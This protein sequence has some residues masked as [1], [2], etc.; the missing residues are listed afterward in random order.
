MQNNLDAANLSLTNDLP[1][2]EA[3]FP[4]IPTANDV[5]DNESLN[6][7]FE[8][9][10]DVAS[11]Y[12]Y[13]R[14]TGEP[15]AIESLA[16]ARQLTTD[17]NAYV[18]LGLYEPSEDTLRMVQQAFNLHELAIEDATVEHQRAKI[19]TY[20]EECIFI[21][22]RTAKLEERDILYGTTSIF[23][24]KQFV[25]SIRRGASHSYKAVRNNYHQHPN[26]LKMGPSF[27]VHAIL[28]FIVDNY[29][30]IT[31]RLG[32]YLQEQERIIFSDKFDRSTLRS[33]Y[34]LKSQLIHLRAIIS[35]MQDICSFFIIHKKNELVS[36]FPNQVKPYFRDIQDHVLRS[37]DAIN[38][39]NE[40]LSLAMDTY[41]AFVTV[42]QNT[43]V[44]KLAA[45][46][47][48][49]AVPT[50]IASFYGM[51][52]KHMPELE[53]QYGYFVMMFVMIGIAT[54]LWHR[55]KKAGWL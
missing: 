26:K 3:S 25:I 14:K 55:F 50:M 36:F 33:L 9:I 21:V 43:V 7:K 16:E 47:G 10:S 15:I 18:W 5:L 35:P 4:K 41:L 13:S 31:Q 40:M 37:L 46:A 34:E 19:E 12:G 1:V 8:D 32:E 17:K 52:F 53:W 27:V 29:I 42:S 24:G 20:G 30:P 51:N 11:C 54:L 48:I 2:A 49:L 23:L 38:G 6:I 45:W 28:D 39:L 44:R 22:A